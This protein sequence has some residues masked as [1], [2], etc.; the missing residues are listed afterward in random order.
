VTAKRARQADSNNK[1]GF[2][3][4]PFLLNSELFMEDQT[5][6]GTEDSLEPIRKYVTKVAQAAGL[7]RRA[8]YNLCL[9]VDEIATNVV[10]HGYR[11]AGL[12][13][14][15]RMGASVED[16]KLVIRMQDQGKSYDPSKHEL[17]KAEHLTTPLESRSIGGLGILLA[18]NGVDDLQ[19][20]STEQGNLHR[21]VI[22]LEFLQQGNADER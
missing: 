19:Y 8:S 7:D 3:L 10:Q 1:R 15:I 6:P 11:E 9:A 5:F 13:G 4:G 22:D 20:V 18:Q 14:T 16:G 17:P 21:F 12:S 2:A